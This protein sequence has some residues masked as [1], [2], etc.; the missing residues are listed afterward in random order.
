MIPKHWENIKLQDIVLIQKGKKPSLLIDKQQ[1]GFIPYLD[2]MAF[3]TKNI[4]NYA[5]KTSSNI[6][7]EKEILMVADGSRS[8]LVGSGFYGAIGSTILAITPI[9]L[10]KNYLFY[11]LSGCYN[12]LNKNVTGTSI[13]HVNTYQLKN[14]QVPLPPLKEQKQIADKLDEAFALI[15]E[16]KD[17][18]QRKIRLISKFKKAVLERAVNGKLIHGWD[19]DDSIWESKTLNEVCNKIT[20]GEHNLPQIQKVGKRLLSAKNIRDGYIDYNDV[21]FISETDFKKSIMRCKPEINDVLIVCVGAT[22]GRC[23]I[24][25]SD[26]DFALTRNVV[27]LKPQINSKYLLYL[28]QSQT[29][30]EKIRLLSQGS[31]QLLLSLNKIKTLTLNIAS[32]SEQQEIVNRVEKLLKIAEDA[33]KEVEKMQKVIAKLEQSVLKKA[34]S[35]ELSEPQADDIPVSQLLEQI[36]AEKEKLENERRELRMKNKIAVEKKKTLPNELKQQIVN[37]FGFS[38]FTSDELKY[39]IENNFDIQYNDIIKSWF[40]GNY[41]QQR[42]DIQKEQIVF[43]IK[44]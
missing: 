17:Y 27:L 5:E 9:L 36:K 1:D 6:G 42:F 2:I 8:G 30:Q 18:I 31:A 33:E 44:H 29:N 20:D 19:F 16:S 26:S 43:S 25:D 15:A 37:K 14:L 41:I 39:F 10:N 3:E 4:R 40:K 34:F 13:P 22:I 32:I 21:S 11:Y 23:A 35:G 12:E 28:L 7:T 24:I 38:E